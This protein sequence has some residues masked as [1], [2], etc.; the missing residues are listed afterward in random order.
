MPY[1]SVAVVH[2]D[3]GEVER[4]SRHSKLPF[5]AKFA[6]SVHVVKICIESRGQHLKKNCCLTAFRRMRGESK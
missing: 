1:V 5:Q 2:L 4:R 6:R 3:L